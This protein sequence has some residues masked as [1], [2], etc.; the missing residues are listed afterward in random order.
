MISAEM[1]TPN[2]Q[3]AQMFLPIKLLFKV[4]RESEPRRHVNMVQTNLIKA[5]IQK[6]LPYYRTKIRTL[7]LVLT[8]LGLKNSV[9]KP[10]INETCAGLSIHKPYWLQ[11]PSPLVSSCIPILS[12]LS[13]WLLALWRSSLLNSNSPAGLQWSSH[14]L[15]HVLGQ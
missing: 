8:S 15:L 2:L 4:F 11:D 1:L 7:I 14:T 9:W 6:I 12:V 3:F 10:R 5:F 13:G